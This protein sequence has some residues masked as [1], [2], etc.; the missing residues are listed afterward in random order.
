MREGWRFWE[1]LDTLAHKVK[2]PWRHWISDRYD[3]ALGLHDNDE[4]FYEDDEPVEKIKAAFERGPKGVTGKSITDAI[5]ADPAEVARLRKARQH[6]RDGYALL[7]ADPERSDLRE[8]RDRRRT[9]P[10]SWREDWDSKEDCER[11]EADI[12][13]AL[14]DKQFETTP[15]QQ[16]D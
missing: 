13:A 6:A 1:A 10:E 11:D 7:A 5:N 8:V 2:F 12:R 15:W 4:D 14:R 3:V 9:P 16:E